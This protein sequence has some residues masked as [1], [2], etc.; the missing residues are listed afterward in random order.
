MDMADAAAAAV[1]SQMNLL[2]RNLTN[3]CHEPIMKSSSSAVGSTHEIKQ[4]CCWL[5][6]FLGHA[7][8]TYENLVVIM[9]VESSASVGGRNVGSHA[10]G[11]PQLITSREGRR[12]ANTDH[13]S[14]QAIKSVKM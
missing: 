10:R 2:A 5:I 6:R 8:S 12:C 7:A 11:P 9:Y 1:Q 13:C 4:L 14:P 3:A